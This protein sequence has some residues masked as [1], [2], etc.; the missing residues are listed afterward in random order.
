MNVQIGAPRRKRNAAVGEPS[1][2][3]TAKNIVAGSPGFAVGSVP[4]QKVSAKVL[5]GS[6]RKFVKGT[7]GCAKA[8]STPF[9]M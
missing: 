6:P 4:P 9:R 8:L 1:A 2:R 5:H 3:A 7:D